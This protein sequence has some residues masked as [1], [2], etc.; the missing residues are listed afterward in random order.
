MMSDM[1]MHQCVLIMYKIWL[2]SCFFHGIRS[3]FSSSAAS[4]NVF[5]LLFLCFSTKAGIINIPTSYLWC[6]KCS[7]RF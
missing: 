6:H 1:F 7:L 5:F 4:E 3:Q 2:E